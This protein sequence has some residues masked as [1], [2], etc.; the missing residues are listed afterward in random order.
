MNYIHIQVQCTPKLGERVLIQRQFTFSLKFHFI[1]KC[2]CIKIHKNPNFLIETNIVPYSKL[3]LDVFFL[4]VKNFKLVI[5]NNRHSRYLCPELGSHDSTQIFKTFETPTAQ[6]I[7]NSLT[8]IPN[9]Y[10]VLK[11]Q[12]KL[13]NICS[14]FVGQSHKFRK[15]K[16][17]ISSHNTAIMRSKLKD[18]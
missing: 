11:R 6:K 16:S 4:Y 9:I 2:M 5:L 12:S 18:I 17:R 1:I 7:V 3:S 13:I 10:C 8:T 15:I 14:F